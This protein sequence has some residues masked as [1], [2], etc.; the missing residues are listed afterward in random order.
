M[1]GIMSHALITHQNIGDEFSGTYYVESAYI[2]K[3]VTNKDY[4]DMLLRDKSGARPVKHWG[5]VKNLSKGSWAF[6]AGGVEEYQGNPSFIGRNVEVVDEPDDLD[7]YIPIYEG[8]DELT[9][10][11]DTIKEMIDDKTCGLLI[12]EVYRNGSFFDKFVRCPGSDGPSYGKRGGLLASVVRIAGHSVDAAKSYDLTDYENS[13]MLTSA[14]LCRVG[15][16]DAYEFED[17]MPVMTKRGILLGVPNLTVT[18]VSSA[19]R[20]VIGT[21]KQ[22]GDAVDQETILRILHGIVAANK[23][24]GVDA[25]TKEAMI[26]QGIVELDSDVVDALDFINSDVNEEEFTAFDTRMRRRYYRG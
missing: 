5:V 2:K 6:V 22:T 24:C 1:E 11:F 17:C 12:D 14:L 20:R 19:L 4:T 21:A 10:Q 3:T 23:T 9:E 13:I 26:L 18:R 7:E 25:M 15:A 16:T 8:C